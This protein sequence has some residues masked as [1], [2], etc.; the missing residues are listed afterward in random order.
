MDAVDP[1]DEPTTASNL[2]PVD[3]VTLEARLSTAGQ[4]GRYRV[5]ARVGAG[6]M[7]IVYKAF[8]TRLHRAVAIKTVLARG[9]ADAATFRLRHEAQLAASLDHPYICRVYELLETVDEQLIVMEFVEGETLASLLRRARPPIAHVVQLGLEIAEG[10]ANAHA[11]GLIHRDL[12]PS[13][14]MV[15][16]HGHIKLLDF[17]LARVDPNDATTGASNATLTQPGAGTPQYMS[18][19]QVDGRPVG[20][21]ADLFSLGVVL[22]ECVTGHLPFAADNRYAYLEQVRTR[23]PDPVQKF[24]PETP[25]GLAGVIDACLERDP[26]KR[27]ASARVIVE[28]LR[29]L[30]VSGSMSQPVDRRAR[31]R[32]VAIAT[33]AGITAIAAVVYLWRIPRPTPITIWQSRPLAT[34]SR[35]DSGSRISPDKR[36]ISYIS[37]IGADT[38]LFVRP[39]DAGTPQPVTLPAGTVVDHLWSPDGSQLVVAMRQ[40]KKNLLHVV[41][42]FFGGAPVQTTVLPRGQIRLR[43]MIERAIFA[44]V[45]DGVRVSLQRFDL[46]HGQAADLSSGWSV[47]GRLRDID[48]SPD[49][50]RAAFTALA[51]DREDLWVINVDGSSI[52]RLTNDRWFERSPLWASGDEEIIYQS[53]RGGQIDL[54]EISPATRNVRQLTSGREEEIPESVSVDGSLVTFSQTSE[55][56]HLWRWD[57][58]NRSGLQLSNE[59]LNDFA[60]VATDNGSTIVFER[61]PA[62]PL[63]SPATTSTLFVTGIG[64]QALLPPPHAIA[65]GFAAALSADGA[66]LA[67][68]RPGPALGQ[69]LCVTKL[70]TTETI[71][72]ST[73]VSKPVYYQFPVEWSSRTFAWD[74]SGPTLY[75][76]EGA[77]RRSIRKYRVEQNGP[78]EPVVTVVED[79]PIRDIRLPANGGALAYLTGF[80]ARF[81]SAAH[82]VDLAS[83]QTHHLGVVEGDVYSR[84]WLPDA[85]ALILVRGR[86]Y[87]SDST[88]DLEI[89]KVSAAAASVESLGSISHGF[90]PST[91]FDSSQAVLYVTRSEAGIHNLYAFALSSRMLTRL[92]DNSLPGV[93]FSG[94]RPLTGGALLAVRSDQKSD[95]WLME[96]ERK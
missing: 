43:R 8:D 69:T 41:P 81:A 64:Q 60:P 51:D 53:N 17:G 86:T 1:V 29:R 25:D 22:F 12:K 35:N 46:D 18:P 56:A 39:I 68:L 89:L 16:P 32:S 30:T 67:Y 95:I 36:W 54:W 40:D 83:G 26:S 74:A 78:P 96:S 88:G 79:T 84:G 3:V 90:L 58:S 44:E 57:R 28:E 7:G 6:G 24:A 21:S 71:V 73:N 55:E 37:R 48:V 62:R 72:V 4:A 50:R 91:R 63:A 14:V 59:L 66:W 38:Q 47:P 34:S 52:R 93:S 92:T 31:R 42:A 15:T 23:R 33:V 11:R 82:L 20:P 9:R 75:F 2:P 65:A 13:N 94:I 80:S 10:L 70:Q 27:P 85:S 45:T 19:E 5:I 76:I 87:D 49:G 61:S 77:N